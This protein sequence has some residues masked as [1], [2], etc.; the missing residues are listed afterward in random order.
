MLKHSESRQAHFVTFIPVISIE[1]AINAFNGMNETIPINRTL[2]TS[3][4]A[5]NGA[6]NGRAME[7]IMIRAMSVERKGPLSYEC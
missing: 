6:D 5:D 3:V 7:F 4:A 1:D 2:T